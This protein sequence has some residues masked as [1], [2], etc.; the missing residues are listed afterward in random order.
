MKQIKWLFFDIGSTLMD[1]TASYQGWF[2][3]ASALTKGILTTQEIE[4]EYRA[5]MFQGTPTVAGQLENV[6][7]D[8]TDTCHLYPSALD[9]P[10]PGAAQV[11]THLS[12]N[13]NL[14]I[15]A[16]Q[17]AG[18]EERLEKFG[19]RQYFDV[20]ISSAEA[21]VKKPDLRIFSLALQQAGCTSFEAAMI[22]DRLDNDIIPA[23]KLGFMTVRVVQ[24]Y[25]RLLM[26]KSEKEEP[27]FS[28]N[29]LEDLL[30]LFCC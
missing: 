27:D 30:P 13:Y 22:G 29:S 28:V 3:N 16:N 26:P 2:Q 9:I 5:G 12:E 6:G 8:G 18:S 15:I 20:I 7:F 14:G 21:G 1:E 19:L 24:G 4:R 11:L 17:N 25:S 23:K 10:Y